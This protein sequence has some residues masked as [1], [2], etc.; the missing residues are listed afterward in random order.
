MMAVNALTATV[1][2]IFVIDIKTITALFRLTNHPR[3]KLTY[4]FSD[5]CISR[6]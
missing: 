4:Y 6:P 3:Q 1:A 2:L 5:Y